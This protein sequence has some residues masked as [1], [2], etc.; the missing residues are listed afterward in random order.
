M[1][2]VTTKV[3]VFSFG[4]IMMEMMTKRRPTGVAADDGSPL[5]LS[6]LVHQALGRGINGLDQIMDPHLASST[7]NNHEALEGLFHLALSCSSTDPEN[8]PDMEQVLASLS[9]LRNM[10]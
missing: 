6:Q 7:S 10:F 5:T 2:K 8:R 1:M 3:D 9:K 4:I